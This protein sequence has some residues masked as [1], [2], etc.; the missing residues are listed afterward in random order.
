MKRSLKIGAI[1]AIAALLMCALV[2][3]GGSKAT[4][5]DAYVG[6]WTLTSMNIDGQA[7]SEEEVKV[8]SD[9][10]LEVTLVL[11]EDGSASI[12]W[13]DD[14][15][16]GSWELGEDDSCMLT[17][18]GDPATANIVDG[19]LRLTVPPSTYDFTKK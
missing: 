4:G 3:C 6:T 13:F 17:I 16:S 10:S 19:K 15:R 18:N 7:Y 9:M 2:A 1:L 8:L 11:N 5:K 12:N 14:T